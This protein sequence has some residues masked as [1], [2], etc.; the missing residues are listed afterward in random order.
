MVCARRGLQCADKFYCCHFGI[1]ANPKILLLYSAVV[2]WIH[3]IG[4]KSVKL[5]LLRLVKGSKHN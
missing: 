3:A 5:S 2:E 1:M 4:R